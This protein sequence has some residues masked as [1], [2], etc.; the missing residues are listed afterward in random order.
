M[1]N[2]QQAADLY[3]SLLVES[4]NGL[5]LPSW[6]AKVFPYP[7]HDCRVRAFQLST[8]TE[9]MAQIRSGPVITRIH[10]H[11]VEFQ[12]RGSARKLFTYSTHDTIICYIFN[13]MKIYYGSD[14]LPYYGACIVFEL[15]RNENCNEENIV[16]VSDFI[17]NF[18]F[19]FC[20]FL[21][22][23][24]FFSTHNRWYIMQ[25]APYKCQ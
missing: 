17:Y 24:L 9:Y 19:F 14:P 21:S 22:N 11:M 2:C 5:D 6:T 13:S 10:D 15:Y 4:D 1:T 3:D 25:I 20:F 7:L 23:F 16:Q 12:I 8:E 18:F